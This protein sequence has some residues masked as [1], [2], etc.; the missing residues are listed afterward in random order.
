MP[1]LMAGM[2][3]PNIPRLNAPESMPKSLVT[4]CTLLRKNQSPAAASTRPEKNSQVPP[5]VPPA[6]RTRSSFM[7]RNCSMSFSNSCRGDFAMMADLLGSLVP[8]MLALQA[9]A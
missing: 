5:G 9:A 3:P 1:V 8:W 7:V 4:T 2:P 6:P